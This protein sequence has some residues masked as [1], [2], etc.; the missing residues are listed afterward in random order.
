MQESLPTEVSHNFKNFLFYSK[1]L[2]PASSIRINRPKYLCGLTRSICR[3]AIF[4]FT[5]WAP[6]W[7]FNLAPL[8]ASALGLSFPTNSE[9]FMNAK[10]YANLLPYINSS[11]K[12]K[13][14]NLLTFVLKRSMNP[15][16]L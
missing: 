1:F 9:W 11:G 13:S 15:L 4:H 5:C 6:F 3:I 2:G 12:F 8:Y 16:F 7:F 10:L 14:F